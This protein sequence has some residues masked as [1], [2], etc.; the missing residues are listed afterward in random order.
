MLLVDGVDTNTAAWVQEIIPKL[1]QWKEK[2][3]VVKE[4]DKIP[5]PHDIVDFLN[6]IA[7]QNKNIRTADWNILWGHSGAY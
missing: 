3:L 4:G 1:R 2:K 6:M 5:K 7:A